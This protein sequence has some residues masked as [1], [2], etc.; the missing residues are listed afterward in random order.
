MILLLASAG[1]FAQKQPPAWFTVSTGP[2]LPVGDFSKTDLN[3]EGSGYAST[4]F[5]AAIGYERRTGKTVGYGVRLSGQLNPLDTRGMAESFNQARFAQYAAFFTNMVGNI[6]PGPTTTVVYPNWQF[7]KGSWKLLSLQGGLTAEWSMGKE[8]KVFFAPAI[9]TGVVYAGLPAIE[10]SSITD[11]AT[12]NMS[13]ASGSTFGIIS[14]VEGNLRFMLS[15]KISLRA[16]LA[17]MQTTRLNFNDIQVKSTTTKGSI[18][19]PSFSI[20]QSTITGRVSQQMS[21]LNIS[22]GLLLRL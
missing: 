20:F 12:A 22:A 14:T 1:A 4:G 15:D 3:N 5:H 18:G 6:P 8:K 9:Y 7:S 17:F 11:T 2:A 21:S 19:S 16:G 13:Q 10:G